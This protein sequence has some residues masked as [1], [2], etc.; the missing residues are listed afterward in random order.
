MRIEREDDGG[1]ALTACSLPESFDE[2]GMPP[3]HAV[4]VADGDSPSP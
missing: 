1:P 4:K 3:M 2:N